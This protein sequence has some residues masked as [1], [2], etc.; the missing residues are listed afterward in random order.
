MAGDG[1][2]LAAA[3]RSFDRDGS[4]SE[5]DYGVLRRCVADIGRIDSG[6]IDGFIGIFFERHLLDD[7]RR[8]DLVALPPDQ[9][10]RAVRHRFK[11]VV[12]GSH[13]THQV[14][15]ALSAHVREALASLAG[16]GGQFPVSIATAQGFSSIS[17][18][19]A[20]G[21]LWAERGTRPSAREATGE[22]L[23]RYL[24]AKGLEATQ[25]TGREFPAVVS[26]K[27]DAQRLARGILELLSDDEKRL[28][29]AQL[30][31]ESVD[32]WCQH[33]RYSRAT[34]YRMLARIKALV[35]TEFEERSS[36]TRL[37]VL[38]A[39]RGGLKK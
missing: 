30:D 39:I 28:F 3:L 36:R 5:D 34:A 25:T 38:D 17:V 4:F 16:P 14:W 29:R 6:L 8:A 19:Q 32:E 12:A 11:Q 22:L 23:V 1:D 35:K 10:I 13:D 21:A 26:A 9:L 18:E 24:S 15:H 37:E 33:T 2:E 31:G 27:L 7:V 20:V